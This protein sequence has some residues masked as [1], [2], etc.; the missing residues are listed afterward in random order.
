MPHEGLHARTREGLGPRGRTFRST[1]LGAEIGSMAKANAIHTYHAMTR[2]GWGL[3]MRRAMH[4]SASRRPK[5]HFS[6]EWERRSWLR[7]RLSVKGASWVARWTVDSTSLGHAFFVTSSRSRR[8]GFACPFVWESSRAVRVDPSFGPC[9]S[10]LLLSFSRNGHPSC[11]FFVGRTLCLDRPMLVRMC[12]GYPY[13]YHPSRGQ[14]RN[15]SGGDEVP[16]PT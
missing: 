1:F 14:R 2:G 9:M 8:A 5:T 13:P 10:S 12:D 4:R 3:K 7:V 15:S 6:C 16:D 11:V